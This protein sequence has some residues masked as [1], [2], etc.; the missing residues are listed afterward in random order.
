MYSTLQG[1]CDLH[2]TPLELFTECI[3]LQKGTKTMTRP[4]AVFLSLVLSACLPALRATEKTV[5]VQS[6]VIS[7]L[8]ADT[9]LV[10]QVPNVAKLSREIQESPLGKIVDLPDVSPLIATMKDSL[11]MA[12]AKAQ[13]EIG[14]DPWDIISSVE[15]E[16]VLAYGSLQPL[17]KALTD[18]L[19]GLPPEVSSEAISI[20]L[21]VDAGSSKGKLK[22]VFDKIIELGRKEG[23]RIDSAE[24]HGSQITT[25]KPPE[26]QDN[27]GL[28][29]LY[30]AE[31]GT[32]FML[33]LDKKLL[34]QVLVNLDSGKPGGL[35]ND[36]RFQSTYK[37]TGDGSDFFGYVNIKSLTTSLGNSLSA[38]FFGFFWQK[39]QSLV[40]GKSLNNLGMAVGIDKEGIRQTVFL[41]NDGADDGIVGWLRAPGIEP[42][43]PAF[44]PESANMVGSVSINVAKVFAFLQ[45]LAQTALS[46]QGGGDVNMLFEQQ[47]GVK[48]DDLKR[49]F[50]TRIDMFS[51]TVGNMENPFGDVTLLVALEDASPIRQLLKRMNTMAPG[52]FA[53]EQYQ[54]HEVLTAPDGGGPISPAL[55]ITDKRLIFSVEAENVRKVL[56]RL[57][58]ATSPLT[59]RK[60][61]KKAA[62]SSPGKV[63]LF[64]YQSTAYNKEIEAMY[65]DMIEQ[66]AMGLRAASGENLPPNIDKAL[67]SV[68]KALLGSFDDAFGWGAWKEQG[69]YVQATTP[70]K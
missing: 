36:P 67:L 46:F 38:T 41:H 35:V 59:S 66:M 25:V 65:A 13:S 37:W 56:R 6:S 31:H 23:A 14:I 53:T 11:K 5:G 49:A 17:E 1:P 18:Q 50:G 4:S 29:A 40:F 22:A 16:L 44:T 47:F 54:G 58:N 28:E 3:F 68:L 30:L 69:F 19:S 27:R 39:F 52:T 63:N 62:A 7:A 55:C 70:F 32:K 12:R 42:Q 24:F 15:G 8:P 51:T 45:D 9:V 2:D 34:E 48:L 43:P 64:E 10:V 33:A 26:G 57:K 21:A 60:S 20:L 61:F